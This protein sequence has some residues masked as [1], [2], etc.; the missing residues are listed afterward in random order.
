[1]SKIWRTFWQRKEILPT[2]RPSSTAGSSPRKLSLT[3]GFCAVLCLV[4]ERWRKWVI[5]NSRKTASVA[6]RHRQQRDTQASTHQWY[7]HPLQLQLWT[8]VA[9]K[10]SKSAPKAYCLG[11]L[12]V[13]SSHS[14]GIT[15]HRGS[16]QHP[17]PKVYVIGR[18]WCKM[19][20]LAAYR[21]ALLT[22]QASSTLAQKVTTSRRQG[23][24]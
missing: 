8:C 16:L 19:S 12:M 23:S 20:T 2:T 22:C 10:W 11:S 13:D 4:V 5:C 18:R 9:A 7:R 24:R 1:M 3:V 14:T 15:C 17:L 6:V 21:I